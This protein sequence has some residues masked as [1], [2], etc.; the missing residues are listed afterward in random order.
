MK[1]YLLLIP[2]FL[3]FVPLRS[4]NKT[5]DNYGV[6]DRTIT[7]TVI[8]KVVSNNPISKELAYQKLEEIIPYIKQASDHF[9]IPKNILAAVLYE[10]IIH[11]KPIDV[12]TF[13]VAQL[14]LGELE[15]QGIPLSQGILEDD[16]VSV[17][18]LAGKLRRLQ[19][20][21]G[22][23]KDAII[24]HNGYYDY[25]ES[26]RNSANNL[27]ILVLLNQNHQYQTFLV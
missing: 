12:K 19:N 18:L 24:L 11:R 27:R 14:G 2:L 3:S 20:K 4:E 22:S 15:E 21:T 5:L 1:R 6:K 25:Y 10:E 13:G 8:S 7:P 16:E 9:N 17:W 26:V 23:L